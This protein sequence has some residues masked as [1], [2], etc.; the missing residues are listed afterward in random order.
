MPGLNGYKL[1]AEIRQVEPTLPV[2]VASGMMGDVDAGQDLA[3]LRALG[4]RVLL[5]KPFA[6]EELMKALDAELR[7]ALSEVLT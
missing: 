2:V 3:A 6:E 4:V 7:P 5:R 1:V